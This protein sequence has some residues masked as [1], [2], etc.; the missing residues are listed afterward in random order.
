[1]LR[2]YLED[3]RFVMPGALCLSL[4][5]AYACK[6]SGACCTAGWTIPVEAPE[7]HRLRV[8]FGDD[9]RRFVE[10]EDVAP[11]TA[12]Y[13]GLAPTGACVFYDAEDGGLCAIHRDVGVDALPSACRHFPRVVLHDRRGLRVSLSHYCP[14]AAA[15]LFNDD[16]LEIVPAPPSL[17]LDGAAEGL[18][19]REALPPLLRPGMLADVE[20]YDTWERRA[21][22]LLVRRDVTAGGA[23][24]AI[25][26]ATRRIQ[27]WRPGAASLASVVDREFDALAGVEHGEDPAADVRRV[28]LAI[29]SVP[30]G[31]SVPPALEEF[32]REW[33]L[34]A[35]RWPELDRVLRAYLAARLFGNWV[36]YHGSGL[37]AIVA[38]L[39]VALSVVKM[40]AVRAHRAEGTAASLWQTVTRAIQ[41][42]DLL[43]VHLS[44]PKDLA[45]RLS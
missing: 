41:N 5:R 2:P 35:P 34:L 37:Q 11:G 24:A 20:G 28:A 13:L 12:A 9:A 23:L 42:A 3:H 38:Y 29:A 45:R 39:R 27:S 30:S 32:E 16:P 26:D 10:A 44:D 33:P 22:A 21:I 43:L 6:H 17:T 19:A 7:Y 14:T 25:G 36:A 40:E 31:L 8:H 15:L 1:L 18:D 4:H